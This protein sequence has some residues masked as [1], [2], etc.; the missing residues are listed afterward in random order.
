MSKPVSTIIQLAQGEQCARELDRPS[1]VCVVQVP[2]LAG[3]DWFYFRLPG[4][5]VPGLSC[6]AVSRLVHRPAENSKVPSRSFVAFVVHQDGGAIRG[7]NSGGS[8]A[9]LWASRERVE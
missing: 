4:T 7:C 5:A 1:G 3:L 9:K 2:S 8:Q 6:S